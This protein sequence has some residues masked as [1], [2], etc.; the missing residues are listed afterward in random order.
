MLSPIIMRLGKVLTFLFFVI[1]VL[2][3][4]T[5]LLLGNH[6]W[7]DNLP[8]EYQEAALQ[9]QIMLNQ[10]LQQAT[11]YVKQTIVKLRQQ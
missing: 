7:I 8:D 9:G 11:E 10:T 1:S 4:L 3:S 2:N 6:S 5:I